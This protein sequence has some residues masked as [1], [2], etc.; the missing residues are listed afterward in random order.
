MIRTSR[1]STYTETEIRVGPLDRFN[2]A[3]IG[4]R[5]NI[6]QM[7]FSDTTLRRLFRL[8][9]AVE[10]L[11]RKRFVLHKDLAHVVALLRVANASEYPEVQEQLLAVSATLTED[12]LGFFRTLGIDLSAQAQYCTQHTYHG[13]SLRLAFK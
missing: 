13:P 9:K 4:R 5:M 11:E 7:K 8:A 10:Q 3:A 12:N 2:E 6:Q 1:H